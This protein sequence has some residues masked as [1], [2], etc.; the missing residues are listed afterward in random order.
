VA[1]A[2]RSAGSARTFGYR[3]TL[4]YGEISWNSSISGAATGEKS[5]A[6]ADERRRQQ[7]FRRAGSGG[8]VI[9]WWKLGVRT[10]FVKP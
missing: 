2:H 6:K 3:K 10:V 4:F 1:G 5:W 7:E 8:R 9:F